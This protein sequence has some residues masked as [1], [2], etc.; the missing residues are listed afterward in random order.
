MTINLELVRASGRRDML[1][2]RKGDVVQTVRKWEGGIHRAPVR[3]TFWRD[4]KLWAAGP[5]WAF[6]SN[7]LVV[8]RKAPAGEN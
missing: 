5:G 1:P 4:G 6:P 7:A 8:L 3:E 2:V